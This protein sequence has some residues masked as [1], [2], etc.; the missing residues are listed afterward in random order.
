MFQRFKNTREAGQHL[1]EALIQYEGSQDCLILAL[2]RGG[3]PVAYEVAKRLCLPLDILLVR[4]L[5]V[6]RHEEYAMGAIASGGIL[7]IN[8]DVVRQL[9]IPST[10]IDQVRQKE[11]KELMRREK[12]YR[13]KLAAPEIKGKTVIIVDDGLA[14]GATAKAAIAA[15]RETEAAKIIVAVPVGAASTCREVSMLVDKLVCLYRPEP[16][17]GV[18]QWYDDF[19]QTS[20][21]EVQK[22]LANSKHQPISELANMSKTI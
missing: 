19:S 11:Q 2:P 22:L 5:G 9:H 17:G 7:V 6:P 12:L 20:D 15:L 13:G 4:K 1:A 8:Q 14:T 16:F 18:G 21:D 3:V 10:A